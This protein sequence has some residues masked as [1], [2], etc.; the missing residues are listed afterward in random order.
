M[1]GEKNDFSLDIQVAQSLA[2]HMS[3]LLY[4]SKY[5]WQDYIIQAECRACDLLR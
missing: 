5:R 3:C 2:D 1:I 4:L